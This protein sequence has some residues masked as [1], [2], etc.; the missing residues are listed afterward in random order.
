[1]RKHGGFYSNDDKK[2]EEIGDR[3]VASLRNSWIVTFLVVCMDQKHNKFC[4]FLEVDF[5]C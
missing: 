4:T 5:L 3:N 2:N 1:M